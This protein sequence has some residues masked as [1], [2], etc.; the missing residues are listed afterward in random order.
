MLFRS[1]LERLDLVPG[2]ELGDRLDH[3]RGREAEGLHQRLV[4]RRQ[5]VDR[6][7]D[8]LAVL[9]VDDQALEA[10]DAASAITGQAVF[11][12]VGVTPAA[13]QS[14]WEGVARVVTI[15][16]LHG[17]Y[18][19]FVDMLNTAGLIDAQGCLRFMARL[20]DYLR[21]GGENVSI[22]EVENVVETHDD[23]AECIAVGVPD[24]RR[25]EVVEQWHSEHLGE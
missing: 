25:V 7:E 5:R 16:D 21:V 8:P 20:K 10:G 3:L 12:A 4:E 13:A 18:A 9:L 19:K 23:V 17:D 11:A 15:G 14:Q 24:E 2:L 6:G 22:E 1:Q